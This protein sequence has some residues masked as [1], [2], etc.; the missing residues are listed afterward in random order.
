M[1]DASCKDASIGGIDYHSYITRLKEICIETLHENYLSEILIPFFRSCCPDVMKIVPVFDDRATGKKPKGKTATRNR[2]ETICAET[3]NGKYIVPDYIFVPKGYTVDNPMKPCLMVEVK[4][5]ILL[6]R[7][8]GYYYRPLKEKMDNYEAELRNE[9][10]ANKNRYLIFTDCITWMF[11]TIKDDNIVEADDYTPH[12][13]LN[14]DQNRMYH[15]TQLI[16]EKPE[17]WSKLRNTI[18]DLLSL[19]S[20]QAAE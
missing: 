20:E 15:M 4:K 1:S 10:N 19:Y 11:L 16:T 7:E 5:P 8:D 13:L 18:Y 12:I 17:E 6:K 14:V 3:E 9:I 2:M